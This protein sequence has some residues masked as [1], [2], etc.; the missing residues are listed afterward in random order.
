MYSFQNDYSEGAHPKVL[1][2]LIQANLEQNSGYGLD[3][4]SMK[5]RKSISKRIG[6]Q[7]VDIHFIPAGTQTNLLLISSCLRPFEAVIAAASGHI[8]VHETGAI[9]STGH[10]VIA[11]SS[12]DESEENRGKLTERMIQEAMDIHTDEHMVKP[13]MVYISNS[14]EYGTVYT[15]KELAK[16]SHY[17]RKNELLLFLDGARL[18]SALV[19]L[20]NDL[21]LSDL[22]EYTDAFYIGGTKNGALCGEALVLCNESLKQEFRYHMKQRGAMFAKGFVLGIQF[23][24]LF[25]DDLYFEL[26]SH[27]NVMAGRIAALFVKN[28]Y[29]FYAAPQTNQIFVIMSEQQLAGLEGKIGVQFI[30]KTEGDDCIVRFVTSWATTPDGIDQLAKALGEI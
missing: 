11:M 22:A 1:E 26:A 17:C 13:R 10:K 28:G 12:K 2:G 8:N 18:G 7:K 24:V 4:H 14:T 5:A 25:E 9:E 19:S 27:A 23:E 16:I 21:E 20:K 6:S 3:Q 29:Q 15:K 30:G